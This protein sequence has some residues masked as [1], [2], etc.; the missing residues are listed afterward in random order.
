MTGRALG[1]FHEIRRIL[2][3]VGRRGGGGFDRPEI[4]NLN[5]SQ[6]V[7][8]HEFFQRRAP[9]LAIVSCDEGCQAVCATF[10]PTPTDTPDGDA[11]RSDGPND[12][13]GALALLA[14]VLGGLAVVTLCR[15]TVK[16]LRQS[17]PL[18]R[19]RSA[20]RCGDTARRR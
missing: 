2:R 15:R 8:R 17:S 5:Y 4:R 16:E 12:V 11:R 19:A 13:A 18:P 7:G 3:S 20:G 14:V 6:G 9:N 1:S 10:T